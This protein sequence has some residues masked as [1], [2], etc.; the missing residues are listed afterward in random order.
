M[1]ITLK[2]EFFYENPHDVF[3]NL[4]YKRIYNINGKTGYSQVFSFPNRKKERHVFECMRSGDW[5]Y[6]IN[7][8]IIEEG[9]D[10]KSLM[11]YIGE[12]ISHKKFGPMLDSFVSF[13]SEKLGIESFPNIVLQNNILGQQPSFAS[14]NPQNNTCTIFTKNRH[15]LDIFRSLAHEMI[16]HSQNL[17]GKLGFDIEKEGAT[18]SDIE[19]EANSKAGEIMRLFAKENPQYFNFS[20]VKENEEASNPSRRE[21]GTT[22]LTNLYKKGTPGQENKKKIRYKKKTLTKENIGTD[23]GY[24]G[25]GDIY[26][27]VKSPS[28]LGFGYSIPMNE[29]VIDW[30]KNPIIQ[31]RFI[32]RWGIK[33][34]EKLIEAA[35]KINGKTIKHLREAWSS[36]KDPEDKLG[37]YSGR[38]IGEE[39]K[40]LNIINIKK[41]IKRNA[42]RFS[43][44]K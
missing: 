12:E 21:L 44:K 43:R 38:E 37:L 29:N 6:L 20:Y 27:V 17:N 39:N 42:Q 16:H 14:Y 30:I 5:K 28:G 19:N 24:N 22:S 15:P 8:N 25:I 41:R 13:A 2:E 35:E 4:G 40:N 34:E 26:G 31:K 11:K 10:K 33:A 7:E 3:L 23:L 36:G 9:H 1:K 32:D 18:G